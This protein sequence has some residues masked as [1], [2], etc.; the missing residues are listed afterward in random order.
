LD[1][2]PSGLFTADQLNNL[3]EDRIKSDLERLVKITA[4]HPHLHGRS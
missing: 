2:G 1:Y 3:Q 4:A